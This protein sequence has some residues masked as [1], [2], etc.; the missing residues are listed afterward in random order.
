MDYDE[1]TSIKLHEKLAD[2]K[3]CFSRKAGRFL[4]N[5]NVRTLAIALIGFALFCNLYSN[6]G[7]E[8]RIELREE[9][10]VSQASS[11]AQFLRRLHSS[12]SNYEDYLELTFETPLDY[13]NKRIK[14]NIFKILRWALVSF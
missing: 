14:E 3:L 1:L 13:H 7:L 8:P 10:F 6:G 11:S 9:F 12:Y 2:L 4:S 5:H